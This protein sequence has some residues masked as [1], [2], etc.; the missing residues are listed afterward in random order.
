MQPRTASTSTATTEQLQ[1]DCFRHCHCARCTARVHSVGLLSACAVA[2]LHDGEWGCGVVIGTCRGGAACTPASA[3]PWRQGSSS[4]PCVLAGVVLLG[5][6]GRVRRRRHQ[7]LQQ[8]CA[9]VVPGWCQGSSWCGCGGGGQGVWAC[10]CTT[11]T[12][13]DRVFGWRRAGGCGAKWRRLRRL[14]L[15]EEVLQ[16]VPSSN[17]GSS[18]VVGEQQH[19]VQSSAAFL[20]ISCFS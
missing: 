10:L 16:S 18:S 17:T 11:A 14:L 19:A 7:Q 8:Q 13:K 2:G 12:S 4:R 9:A 6:L 3:A 5:T 15:R 1:E 20:D